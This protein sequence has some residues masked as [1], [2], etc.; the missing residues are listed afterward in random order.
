MWNKIPEWEKERVLEVAR[1]YPEKSCRAM[2]AED[3]KNTLDMAIEKTGVEHVRVVHRPRL[4]SDNGGCF[5]SH[6]LKKYL[7]GHA[8]P[9]GHRQCDTGG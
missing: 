1:G 6:E 5:I 9:R 2:N 7:E 8:I 3:V 4:L